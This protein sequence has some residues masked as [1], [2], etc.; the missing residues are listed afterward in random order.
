M[1]S[2]ERIYGVINIFLKYPPIINGDPQ[3]F[4][5]KVILYGE[6]KSYNSS[7]KLISK[8]GHMNREM[9]RL[10]QLILCYVDV[11]LTLSLPS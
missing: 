5:S 2:I 9:E 8:E 6:Y 4:K 10:Q 7:L 3:S 11:K 1:S